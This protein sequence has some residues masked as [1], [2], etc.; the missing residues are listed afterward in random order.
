[1]NVF[2]ILAPMEVRVLTALVHSPASAPQDE[3]ETD[4]TQVRSL[5]PKI[6]DLWPWPALFYPVVIGILPAP[7]SCVFQRRLYPDRGTWEHDCNSCICHD[8]V[9]TC[10]N[11]SVSKIQLPNSKRSSWKCCRNGV[12]RSTVWFT[13]IWLSRPKLAHGTRFASFSR[14]HEWE[15]DA[16]ARPVC[17]VAS[18]WNGARQPSPSPNLLWIPTACPM[19][20]IWGPT[21]PKLRWSS[22]NYECLWWAQYIPPISCICESYKL[23][24]LSS[25]ILFLVL[26]SFSSL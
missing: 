21:V 11:V 5:P 13:P 24:T 20:L 1:M 14:P 23:S 26:L 15:R 25:R 2:P 7:K 18:V 16:S 10:T 22:T 6:S 12:D 9:V 8:G 3:L 17:R 19:H 4:V